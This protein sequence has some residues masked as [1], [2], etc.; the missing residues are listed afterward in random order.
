MNLSCLIMRK[1][2]ASIFIPSHVSSRGY[3][4][5]LVCLCV[6]QLAFSRLNR[7]SYGP[8]I[9][10]GGWSW[11][12]LDE[13]DGQGHGSKFKVDS[14]KKCDFPG[15]R[16]VDLCRFTLSC[17]MTSH[18]VLAR[19]HVTSR[20]DIIWRL[21]ARKRDF[22]CCDALNVSVRRSMGQEYWH[23]GTAW[24]GQHSGVFIFIPFLV[25]E[26]SVSSKTSHL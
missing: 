24:E 11:W 5:G 7:L 25:E 8:R 26:F 13:F 3:K 21:W 19:H 10:H 14:L 23:R 15:V 22:S 16:Q 20:C 9:W 6:C 4:N 17:P 18:S 1:R 2:I 12:Y